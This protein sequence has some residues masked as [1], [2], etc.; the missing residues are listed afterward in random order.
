MSAP[1][2]RKREA[3]ASE[4]GKVGSISAPGRSTRG[5]RDSNRDDAVRIN[6]P[7]QSSTT[8]A[9]AAGCAR[10]DA[11]GCTGR[12]AP[13]LTREFLDSASAEASQ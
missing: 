3:L 12:P 6:A 4:S 7:S 10:T 5:S 9:V 8:F 2:R 11:S 1:G 13:R